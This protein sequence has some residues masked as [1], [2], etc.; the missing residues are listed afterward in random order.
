MFAKHSLQ[1][2]GR[3]SRGLKGTLHS[4]P[5]FAQ[6]ASY[7]TRLFPGIAALF[8]ALGL[9]LEAFLCVE[10]LLTGGEHEFFAAFFTDKSFV[11][12]HVLNLT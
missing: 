3:S 10:L 4:A 2:T 11:F 8:A 9:I 12:V 7:M 5:Q 1:Y 6:T